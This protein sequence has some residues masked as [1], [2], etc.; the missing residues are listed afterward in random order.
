MK[1]IH[2]IAVAALALWI[3]AAPA[4]A[5]PLVPPWGL[6]LEY[7]DRSVRPGDDFFA[8]SNGLWL[9]TVEIPADR[10][11]A[12]GGL[13]VGLRNDERLRTIVAELKTR[14]DLTP[15][16][17]KLRDLYDAYTNEAAIETAGLKPLEKDLAAIAALQSLDDVARVM[18]NPAL[19]LRGPFRF[20]IGADDKHPNSYILQIEQSGLGLPDRDYYLREDKAIA[21]TREAYRKYL[22]QTLAS[23]GVTDAEP[24][25][26]A[27]FALE[28]DIAVAHWP[29]VETDDAEKTYNPMSMP[30]LIAF[31]PSFPWEASL[32]AAGVSP[33]ARGGDRGVLARE[34]SAFPP[35]PRSSRPPRFLSGATI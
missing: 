5:A 6:H 34:K 17:Q 8:Y 24:R 30:E 35:S 18:A 26:A 19:G 11:S 7:I 27:V 12:G 9:K 10:L 32:S 21:A 25:A 23:V 31:A 14:T 29:A 15:E 2:L 33:K 22:A 3:G 13:E 1:T 28:H 4:S 20:Y 16:E